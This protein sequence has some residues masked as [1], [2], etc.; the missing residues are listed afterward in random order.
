M[1]GTNNSRPVHQSS[2]FLTCTSL[3]P[4]CTMHSLLRLRTVIN[5][6]AVSTWRVLARKSVL[7]CVT[8][9]DIQTPACSQYTLPLVI[10]RVAWTAYGSGMATEPELRPQY[11]YG[12]PSTYAKA[13]WRPRDS[14]F[15]YTV[16]TLPLLM[17]KNICRDRQKIIMLLVMRSFPFRNQHLYVFTMICTIWRVTIWRLVKN[18]L[19]D[20]KWYREPKKNVSIFFFF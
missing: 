17:G 10:I 16:K 19:A 2:R 14:F 3:A 1:D 7:I 5:V 11:Q 20:S 6:S 4:R 12:M 15:K 18:S 8:K 13:S 9:R